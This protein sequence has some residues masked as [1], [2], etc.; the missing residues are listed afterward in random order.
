MASVVGARWVDTVLRERCLVEWRWTSRKTSALTPS[1][2][3]P[4]LPPLRA[5]TRPTTRKIGNTIHDG[6][7]PSMIQEATPRPRLRTASASR[8]RFESVTSRASQTEEGVSRGSA[9]RVSRFRPRATAVHLEHS[10]RLL[11]VAGALRRTDNGHEEKV[12]AMGRPYG[13][14]CSADMNYPRP[15]Q[16]TQGFVAS[17][18]RAALEAHLRD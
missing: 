7:I 6:V 11:A 18:H 17:T 14:F 9:G 15:R 4:E 12:P 13:L 8:E 1:Q 3:M 2:T 5:R 16:E 10:E